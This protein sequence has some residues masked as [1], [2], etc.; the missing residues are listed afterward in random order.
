MN[1]GEVQ[2]THYRVEWTAL[3]RACRVILVA[4]LT[5]QEFP[6][7]NLALHEMLAL[8]DVLRNEKPLFFDPQTGVM[9]TAN[10][11]VGESDGGSGMA[12]VPPQSSPAL[13]PRAIEQLLD[14]RGGF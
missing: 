5:G 13:S 2:V 10:E 14:E 1:P 8:V 11:R 3:T 4:S 6:L 12:E 9:R 7:E